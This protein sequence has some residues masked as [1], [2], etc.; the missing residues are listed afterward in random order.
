MAR[1]LTAEEKGKGLDT[2]PSGPPR[3]RMRA[4]DFDPTELIKENL[5]TLVGRLT[6]RKEQKMSSVLP[7]LA[8]KWNLVGLSFS[9]DLG[10]GCFQFRLSKEEDV[11]EVLRNRPYQYGCWMIIV[12]RWEPIISQ[13]FPSQI[14]FWISLRGIPLHYW[15]DKVVCN[16]GMELGELD[17]Y[18]VTRSTARVRVVVDG[19]KPLIMEAAMDYAS[20]EE[21]IISLDYENLGNHCSVCYRLSHLQSQCP[22]RPKTGVT[23]QTDIITSRPARRQRS[24]LSPPPETWESDAPIAS[25]TKP[26]QQHLDRYGRPFGDRVSTAVLR[27]PGPRNKIAPVSLQRQQLRTNHENRPTGELNQDEY[28]SPPYMRRRLNHE[29]RHGEENTRERNHRSPTLQW[30]AKTPI[31][32]QEV[33]PPS[34][35]C[36]PPRQSVGRNLEATNFQSIPEAP[37]REEVI[38]DLMVATRQY[39]N[40]PDPKEAAARKERVLLSEINGDVEEAATR[41]LQNSI[42]LTRAETTAATEP[43]ITEPVITE[44]QSP[45]PQENTTAE[46][47]AAPTRKRG[48]P[49]K[50]RQKRTTVRLSP[51]TY[52][53]MGSPNH[54]LL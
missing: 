11:R 9:S 37:S 40:C 4:P 15:H 44:T 23:K 1:R 45:E 10:N 54:I 13:N 46:T 17:T 6:N 41:I 16:I 50:D 48:R 47:S 31:L 33:T 7:Y 8:K 3:L 36:H 22:E 20:G 5:L 52:A 35:P 43:L 26:F 12:Q 19:L 38:D 14:L 51:K 18:E 2:N 34:A 27:P 32:E 24:P 28:S 53:G 49:P 39:L 42:A 29:D 25:F 21:S 30:R